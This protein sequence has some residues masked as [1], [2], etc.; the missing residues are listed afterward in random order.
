[1]FSDD[2]KHDVPG[3]IL[4]VEIQQFVVQIDNSHFRSTDNS[5]HLLEEEETFV[6]NPEISGKCSNFE[7]DGGSIIAGLLQQPDL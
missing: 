2:K 5:G 6:E 4:Q 3:K 1:M 7:A